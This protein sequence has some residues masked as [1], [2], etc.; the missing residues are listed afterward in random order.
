LPI[1]FFCIFLSTFIV[2]F[3]FYIKKSLFIL[4]LCFHYV[5]FI[6]HYCFY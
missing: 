3:L 6:L 4:F 2:D 1:I 5:K